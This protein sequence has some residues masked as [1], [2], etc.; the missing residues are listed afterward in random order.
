MVVLLH[1]Y[2]PGLDL[3]ALDQTQSSRNHICS[4]PLAPSGQDTSKLCQFVHFYGL[5]CLFAN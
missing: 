2:E 1:L 4:N 3:R 5:F